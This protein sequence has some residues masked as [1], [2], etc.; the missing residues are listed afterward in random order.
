V[1]NNHVIIYV[2]LCRTMIHFS[3]LGGTTIRAFYHHVSWQVYSF[4]VY[5]RLRRRK[6]RRPRMEM[7]TNETAL[8]VLS[9]AACMLEYTG[10]CEAAVEQGLHTRKL[11]YC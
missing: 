4:L 6:L 7:V 1:V 8:D 2:L 9:R 10:N 3:S 11:F 5:F